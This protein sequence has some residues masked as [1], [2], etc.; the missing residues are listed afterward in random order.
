MMKPTGVRQTY[1]PPGLVRAAQGA[2]AAG[3]RVSLDSMRKRLEE[4]RLKAQVPA[5]VRLSQELSFIHLLSMLPDEKYLKE[6]VVMGERIWNEVSSIEAKITKKDP[7]NTWESNSLQLC[8]SM[9]RA[10]QRLGDK[11]LLRHWETEFKRRQDIM[12]QRNRWKPKEAVDERGV[13]IK[14]PLGLGAGANAVWSTLRHPVFD[15][16]RGTA[17]YVPDDDEGSRVGTRDNKD[18]KRPLF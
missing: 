7:S 5:Q 18:Y 9:R 2:V 4:M 10:A 11:E 14:K 15:L 13:R 16:A 6:A 1:V 12:F 17:L 8:A 3:D